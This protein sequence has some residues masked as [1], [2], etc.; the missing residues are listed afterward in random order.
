MPACASGA[1]FSSTLWTDKSRR[2]RICTVK[3]NRDIIAWIACCVFSIGFVGASSGWTWMLAR[4]GDDRPSWSVCGQ[5]MCACVPTTPTAPECPLC[6]LGLS[7]GAGCSSQA[8]VSGTPNRAPILR[9]M[10]DADDAACS[11]M[12]AV[13]VVIAAQQKHALNAVSEP[14]RWSI[15]QSDRIAS[16]FIWVPTPPPRCA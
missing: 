15:A 8:S 14:S 11:M 4:L 6:E 13:F 16:A 10:S 2:D 1:P 7:G 5:D 12:V 9:T 3:T